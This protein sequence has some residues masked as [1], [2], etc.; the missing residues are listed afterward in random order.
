MLPP[1]SVHHDTQSLRETIPPELKLREQWVVWRYELRDGKKTKVPYNARTGQRASATDPDTWCLFIEALQ[2]DGFDGIGYVFSEGD[3]YAGV[4]LDK[5][6]DPETGAI[7]EW[8]TEWVEAFGGY[9]EVSPS[10][11]GLHIFIRGQAPNRKNQKAGTE[12]Y[13]G[14]RF[15]TVTGDGM[16]LCNDIPERQEVLDRFSAKYFPKRRE[17][18]P[19]SCPAGWTID[20]AD[21][22]LLEKARGASRGVGERFAALHDQGDFLEHPSHSEARHELLKHYA[23]WTSWDAPRMSRLYESSALY[24]IPGYARKWARLSERECERAIAATPRAY[25]QE[26][27]SSKETGGELGHIIEALRAQ[28]ASMAWEGRSGPTDRHVY[29]ALISIA[30]RYGT[31]AKK[32]II[33]SADMRTLALDAGTRTATVHKSLKRLREDRGLLRLS[34]KSTSMRAAVYLLRYPTVPQGR[35]TKPC[36][37]YVTPLSKMR[38]PGLTTEKEFDQNGRKL[39]QGTQFLLRRLGKLVALLVERVSLSGE[40]GVTERELADELSRRPDNVH[41]VLVKALGAGL[42]MEGEAGRFR[43]PSDLEWRLQR[44][45]E[46][47]GCVEAHERDV[48]RYREEREAFYSRRDRVADEGPSEEDMERERLQRVQ[49]ALDVLQDSGTGPGMI[50]KSYLA[51]ETKTFDYV[52]SAVAFYY[53]CSG[54]ELWRTPVER[55]VELIRGAS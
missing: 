46:E 33:F 51:G 47:S 55:A 38:N 28:A 5:A 24:A 11:T 18:E 41:R 21:E 12:A 39:S 53:G 8:A 2:A 43:T 17:P 10:G 34:K 27:R 15:F 45:L 7:A 36:E 50:F 14:A 16:S 29:G 54:A 3:P 6:R 37:D 44:E 9:A 26:A 22:D 23:F 35:N 25:G 52:V 20:L 48:N 31:I 49:D 30:A 1:N 32:G 19:E 42:V 4:D 40:G 13:S